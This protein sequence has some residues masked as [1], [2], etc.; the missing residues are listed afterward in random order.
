MNAV[1]SPLPL[2]YDTI[3]PLPL[4]DSPPLDLINLTL[5]DIESLPSFYSPSLEPMKFTLEE[6]FYFK[7]IKAS[8]SND[9][10]LSIVEALSSLPARASLTPLDSQ[11]L[12]PMKYHPSFFFFLMFSTNLMYYVPWR[13]YFVTLYI[14]NIILF[15]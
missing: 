15:C 2:H 6:H 7:D 12:Y 5:D 13:E 10:P 9:E 8:S 11:V 3:S 4:T 14:L 1:S